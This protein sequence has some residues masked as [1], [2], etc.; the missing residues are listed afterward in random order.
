MKMEALG[1]GESEFVQKRFLLCIGLC[2]AAES[3]LST[4]GCRQHDV[5]TVQG[6]QQ[7]QGFRR[8]G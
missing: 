4:I 6:R 5:G 3:N 2:N 8:G 7:R 1:E